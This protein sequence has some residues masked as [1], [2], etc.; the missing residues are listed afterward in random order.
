MKIERNIEENVGKTSG[1]AKYVGPSGGWTLNENTGYGISVLAYDQMLAYSM[2]MTN[3]DP[4]FWMG[5]S[6]NDINTKDGN[7]DWESFIGLGHILGSIGNV[8]LG[9]ESINGSGDVQFRLLVGDNPSIDDLE[10]YK[11][12]APK[13][14]FK[15]HKEMTSRMIQNMSATELKLMGIAKKIKVEPELQKM[16][17]ELYQSGSSFQIFNEAI[18]IFDYVTRPAM[19]PYY[20]WVMIHSYLTQILMLIAMVE[21]SGV[22]YEPG[23]LFDLADEDCYDAIVDA[24]EKINNLIIW[25]GI[26]WKILNENPTYQKYENKI[27]YFLSSFNPM[28]VIDAELE[29]A[30]ISL[31]RTL[32][33]ITLWTCFGSIPTM[34]FA[35][36][37][38]DYDFCV[39]QK[40]YDLHDIDTFEEAIPKIVEDSPE[41]I[42]DRVIR[43]I[44]QTVSNIGCP[45]FGSTDKFTDYIMESGSEIVKKLMNDDTLGD[46]LGNYKKGDIHPLAGMIDPILAFYNIRWK[47]RIHRVES[48]YDFFGLMTDVATAMIRNTEMN[49]GK[50]RYVDK[51]APLYIEPFIVSLVSI[52]DGNALAPAIA[53]ISNV[54]ATWAAISD[55]Y[56]QEKTK[57]FKEILREKLSSNKVED[58]PIGLFMSMLAF[59]ANMGSVKDNYKLEDYLSPTELKEFNQMVN[60]FMPELIAFKNMYDSIDF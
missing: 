26:F 37:I 57:R 33:S 43:V 2:M 49:E 11:Q 29:P 58:N 60:N 18:K 44:N 1:V 3:D 32:L 9:L 34:Q 53:E 8:T 5:I 48:I 20:R 30:L 39:F 24:D 16:F 27:L 56:N 45:T 10:L 31:T 51:V 4:K 35:K 25:K 40:I 54:W 52:N 36:V 17:R 55:G 7:D 21:E 50:L 28:D 59:S 15:N 38:M 22:S 46:W 23:K 6:T 12:R 41:I 14:M 42:R 47:D 19:N 13:A